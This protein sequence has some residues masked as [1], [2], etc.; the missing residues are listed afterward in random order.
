MPF[1]NDRGRAEPHRILNVNFDWRPARRSSRCKRLR[2]AARPRLADGASGSFKIH[3][4]QQINTLKRASGGHI[5]PAE[6]L[7]EAQFLLTG[8]A[9]QCIFKFE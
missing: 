5:A 6:S 4:S 2:L 7:M 1:L 3:C 8:A 9:R